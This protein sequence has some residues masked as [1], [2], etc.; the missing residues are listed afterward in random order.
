MNV[1]LVDARYPSPAQR[2]SFFDAALQ[3]IRALPGVEAAGTINDL[4]FADGSSQTSPS[5]GIPAS[6]RSGGRASSADHPWLPSG[7]GDSGAAW[8]RC[9]RQRCRGAARQ[10]GRRQAVLGSGRSD[11]TPRHPAAF[12]TTVLRQVV[13][14]VGDVK[15]RNLIEP[16]TPTVYYYTRDAFW[17]G[18]VRH[19]DVSAAR[20]ARTACRCSD[21]R[22]RSRAAGRTISGRWCRC[23]TRN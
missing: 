21:P 23:S 19:T 1:R 22:D 2:S 9:R 13:G 18:D 6:A 14:I 12:S 4:P 7:N 17:Q 10:P 11:R 3:R 20:H 16:P 8:A 5:R 15:Q